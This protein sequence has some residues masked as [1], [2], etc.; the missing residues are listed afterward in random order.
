[1]TLDEL[2]TYFPANEDSAVVQQSQE[3]MLR[4]EA[5]ALIFADFEQE[6]EGVEEDMSI[7]QIVNDLQAAG[8][9]A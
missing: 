8:N 6:F 1:M 9:I 2:N 7:P 5:E 3:E 4:Q